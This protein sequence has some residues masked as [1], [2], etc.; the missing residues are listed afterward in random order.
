MNEQK[1]D[2]SAISE[3]PAFITL[4]RKKSVF[5]LSLWVIGALPYLLLILAAAY[6]PE[7]LR[8]RVLGRMNI[9][10]LFCMFQF[11]SMIGI[12]IYYNRKTSRDFDPITK[13]FLDKIHSPEAL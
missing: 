11:F 2:W 6:A 3:T 8:I 9:G 5:L 4:R 13:D 7:L 1:Y 10:Y 12:S